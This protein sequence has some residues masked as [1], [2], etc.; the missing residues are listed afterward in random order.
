MEGLLHLVSAYNPDEKGVVAQVK[1]AVAGGEIE[2]ASKVLSRIKLYGRV[3]T[4][5]AM[6][7]QESLCT[8]IKD[9]GGDYLFRVK[10]NK[11]RIFNDITQEFYFYRNKN[12]GIRSFKA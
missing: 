9:S 4:V 5:D 12:V 6:F 8:Q 3:V 10:Q 11:K 1:S 2:G 7:A